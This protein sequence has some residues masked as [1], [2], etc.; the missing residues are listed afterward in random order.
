MVDPSVITAV[1]FADAAEAGRWFAVVQAAY[2]EITEADPGANWES[3]RQQLMEQAPAQGFSSDT[4]EAFAERVAASVS[5]PLSEVAQIATL[6]GDSAAALYEEA[7]GAEQA[8]GGYEPAADT[9]V[10]DEAVWN[11][12]LAQNGPM[13][14]GSEEAW[15]AFVEWFNYNAAEVGQSEAAAGF[16]SYVE[17]SPDKAAAFAQYGITI[18][19]PADTSAAPTADDS[20]P[21]VPESVMEEIGRPALAEV[22]AE[23]P[24][25]AAL[26]PEEMDAVLREALAE[27]GMAAVSGA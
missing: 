18:A 15:P 27:A 9:Q 22:L 10:Y 12:Y 1:S 8:A 3:F 24:E 17:Q 5:D 21:A 4:A 20:M 16:I 11:E 26:S 23:H 6:G 25:L 7:V 19:A 2:Q 13:W 14:N